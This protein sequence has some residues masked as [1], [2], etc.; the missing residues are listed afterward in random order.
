MHGTH[1]QFKEP[2]E[3]DPDLGWDG[4]TGA[5]PPPLPPD[6]LIRKWRR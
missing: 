4:V 2:D 1:R 5:G 6:L 3:N